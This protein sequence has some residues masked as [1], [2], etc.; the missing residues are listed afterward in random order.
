MTFAE[1]IASRHMTNSPRGNL[2]ADSKTLINAGK[3]P[4]VK[5]WPDLYRFMIGRTA[6][7]EAIDEA[8]KL[9]RSYL[10]AECAS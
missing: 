8:R 5:C 4:D 6:R 2:L 7:P 1:F 10:K 3:F 9:W